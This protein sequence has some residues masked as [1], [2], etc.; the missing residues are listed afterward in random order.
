[1]AR[2][3]GQRSTLRIFFKLALHFPSTVERASCREV[4][5]CEVAVQHQPTWG[6]GERQTIQSARQHQAREQRQTPNPSSDSPRISAFTRSTHAI[7]VH[8]GL[9]VFEKRLREVAKSLE[10]GSQRLPKR[11]IGH[12]DWDL[13]RADRSSDRSESLGSFYGLIPC[14]FFSTMVLFQTRRFFLGFCGFSRKKD[15]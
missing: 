1:M 7:H 11:F 6:S 3:W 5:F 10:T 8:D 15:P 12:S 13:Q 4:L 14:P 9:I 2:F